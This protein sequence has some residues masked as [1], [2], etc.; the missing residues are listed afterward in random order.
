MNAYNLS[1]W[2]LAGICFA[3]WLT[4]VITK[5]YSWVDRIWSIIPIVYTWIFAAGSNLADPRLNTMAVLVTLWGARLTFNF[6]RKG[7][8]APGGEDY[9]W[10]ILREK[11]SPAIYQLFNIFF[12]VI[13]QNVL[14]WLITLPADAVSSYGNKGFGVVDFGFAALFAGFLAME[15]FADQ[16]QWN[17]HQHK[18]A[19][20]A[21]GRTVHP[22]FLQ[23]GWFAVARHPNFFAEQAQWWVL[24]FWAAAITG[25]ILQVASIGA[26]ILTA[27]FIGSAR[28][29][30]QISAEKYP[31]YRDYQRRVSMMVP[32]W[33]KAQ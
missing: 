14:L 3:T 11:M 9:R 31:E 15:F 18:K 28:F 2:V 25:N 33:R 21:A 22:G 16:Q 6:A 20:L 12:I 1:L 13:F 23:T 19:E 7:G 8:Y 10:A 32:S 26:I 30:E 5:E 29:T 27:L 4:S 17:F 24:L